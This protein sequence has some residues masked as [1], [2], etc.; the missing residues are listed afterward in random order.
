MVR[1]VSTRKGKIASSSLGGG[2]IDE[3]LNDVVLGLVHTG[4]VFHWISIQLHPSNS[5]ISIEFFKS[6]HT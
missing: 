5:K 2:W 4:E 6:V 3:N 1:V